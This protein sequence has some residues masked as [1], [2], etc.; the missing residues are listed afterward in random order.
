VPAIAKEEG[1]KVDEMVNTALA[2]IAG[3]AASQGADTLKALDAVASFVADW[4]APKGPLVL[5]L[6]PAKT[7]GL[8]DLDKVMLPDALTTV[9]G[10]TA[11]YP[12]T[13]DGAA[14]AGPSK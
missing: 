4:K 12:G 6:K 1:L 14:K 3:F 10:F 5:G 2:A 9:F 13:R 7:A 11:T 8:S